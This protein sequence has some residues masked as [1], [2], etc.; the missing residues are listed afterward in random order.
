MRGTGAARHTADFCVDPA[1]V[2]NQLGL[3]VGA[4]V[5]VVQAIDIR[6]DNQQ[7]GIAHAC[8]DC[9]QRIVITEVLDVLQLGGCNRV[10]FVDD[11]HNADLGQRGKRVMDVGA[12]VVIDDILARQQDLRHVNAI[13]QKHLVVNVHQLALPDSRRRLLDRQL[14]RSL[15][16]AELCRADRHRTRGYEHHLEAA[17]L[18]V[19]DRAYQTLD[20][21]DIRLAVVISQRRGADLDDN[22]PDL[23][24]VQHKND[25]QKITWKPFPGLPPIYTFYHTKTRETSRTQI[26]YTLY[27]L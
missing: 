26:F 23:V 16:Q 12:L 3:R 5:G 20:T 14:L 15:R 21:A 13:F 8:H 18:Q 10:V 4:R 24:H 6:E 11:G 9:G 19:A 27:T 1:D 25:L 22:A 7:I 2:V 17:V